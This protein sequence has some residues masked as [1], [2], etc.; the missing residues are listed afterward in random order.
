MI[1]R[2]SKNPSRLLLLL[3]SI[4]LAP[5]LHAYDFVTAGIAYN[6][7][8]STDQTVEVT[9]RDGS[10][11][12]GSVS[13]PSSVVYNGVSYSVIAIGNSAFYDCTSLTS[14]SIPNSVT[15]IGVQAFY[16]CRSLISVYIPSSVTTFERDAFS[17]CSS[18]T[19]VTIPNSV[20]TIG[21]RAF[22][23]C[24]SLA[25]VTIPN[26]V[27]TIGS[28]AFTNCSSLTSVIIPNS[29]TT[30]GDGAFSD[31]AALSNIHVDGNN[32]HYSSVDG[33]LFNKDKTTL[34]CHP[35]NRTQ[36]IYTIPNTVITIG[37]YAFSICNSLASVIIP[38][39]V[40]SIGNGAF[41]GC[42]SLASVILP[43]SVMSIGDN[44]FYSCK[45]LA[46]V[47]IPNSVT[48]IGME[49]FNYCYSLT[50]VTIPNSVTT[51]GPRAFSGC[52][53]LT[54]VYCYWDAPIECPISIF[55]EK[56]LKEAIL[57]VPAGTVDAYDN[58]DPWR[59]FWNMVEMST[60]ID[61]V[62]ADE[63]VP[64]RVTVENGILYVNGIKNQSSIAIYNTF[65]RIVYNGVGDAIPNL[66]TGI[67]IV[68]TGNIIAKVV[69]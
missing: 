50:S 36:Q 14:V 45:S 31:C 27:I 46:S 42:N 10:K 52:G 67:Y 40:M 59:N 38:N 22:F 5:S 21:D 17:Y 49:A 44:A 66:P 8:S 68:K 24:Y 18:L 57:Y 43:N 62:V 35:A 69:L 30:I 55:G 61:N 2:L 7:L 3:L 1:K 6:I 29:V 33:L 56:T 41:Y 51:I 64:A 54:S 13:I 53:S 23:M 4:L 65:G 20:T 15:A 25:S 39:S 48:V 63:V 28:S 34:L 60:G 47:T 16:N 58:V 32:Q 9:K 19:S 26:S 11:Y 12:I 37:S